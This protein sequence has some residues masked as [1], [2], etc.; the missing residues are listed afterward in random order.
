[1]FAYRGL[2]I[3]WF[4]VSTACLLSPLSFRMTR[5]VFTCIKPRGAVK[6]DGSPSVNATV[7]PSTWAELFLAI[8]Y[9]NI[10]VEG[11]HRAVETVIKSQTREQRVFWAVR[12]QSPSGYCFFPAA[13][14][15]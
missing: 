2:D 8:E 7:A 3:S 5:V 4:T 10:P 6:S 13:S 1:M 15:A 11:I 9:H 14:V 12:G